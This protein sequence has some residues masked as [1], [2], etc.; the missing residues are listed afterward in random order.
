MNPKRMI[1][2][3]TVAIAVTISST[4]KDD[5]A[6]AY[7]A[8]EEQT[9][10]TLSHAEADNETDPLLQALGMTG[11]EQ[12]QEAQLE[13]KSLADIAELYGAD[14]LDIIKLQTAQ[15]AE[16]LDRRLA[17]GSITADVH[18]AQMAELE[19]IITASVHGAR[20]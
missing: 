9:Q 19:D 8:S 13:G 7:S 3:G 20:L 6:L 12:M 2:I 4:W 11:L 17:E 10:C 16:Q 1:I 18:E 15:L 5:S 14:V